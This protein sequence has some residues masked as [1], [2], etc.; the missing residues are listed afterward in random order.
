MI[1]LLILGIL[2]LLAAIF[3]LLHTSGVFKDLE[4]IFKTEFA[5]IKFPEIKLPKIRFPKNP[6]VS[7]RPETNR[8]GTGAMNGYPHSPTYHIP[9]R[10]VPEP[11]PQPMSEGWRPNVNVDSGRSS[12]RGQQ[13]TNWEI[14]Y[15]W[16]GISKRK[17]VPCF[18]CFSEDMYSG[19]QLGNVQMWYCPNCGQGISL[20][21]FKASQDG[22]YGTNYGIEESNKR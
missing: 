13:L 20:T 11:A 2:L 15:L 5:K 22:I 3:Y 16:E 14:M 6:W 18:H 10:P 12:T 19:T 8:M 7:V 21:I 1:G 9:P 17:R 4:A